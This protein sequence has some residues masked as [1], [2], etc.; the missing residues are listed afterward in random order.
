MSK[1]AP[2]ARLR[3]EITAFLKNTPSVESAGEALTQLVQLAATRVVQEALE[4]EQTDFIGRDRYARAP[5]RGKRNGYVPG[6]LDTAEGRLAVAVP[7]VREAGALYRSV[8]YDFLRGHSDVVQTLAVEMYAR[9]LSTRDIEAAFTDATGTC[10]LSKSA[11]SELTEQLWAE[12]E[13]F[14][15]RDLSEL[16]VLYVFLDGLYEPLRTHGITREAVL[17]AWAITTSGHKVLVH[18][19]L[20]SRESHDDWLGFLRD[21]VRRGLPVPLAITTDG[22]PGL[23]QAVSAVWPKSLRLRCWAHRM[24]N[25]LAKVPEQLHDIVHAEL[26]AIRDAAT[27]AAGQAAA[28]AFLARWGPELPSAATCVSEDLEALLALHRLPWRHRKFVRTTNLIERS[29]VE[30]RRRTKTL[31]RFFTEKSCLKLVYATLIRAAA[32]WQRIVIGQLEHEQLEVLR[33]ELGI[34]ATPTAVKLT[35]AVA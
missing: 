35:T 20:G 27:P 5:G 33:R 7:Q 21:L 8:L 1:L 19:A 31:P 4:Q 16:P 30:E 24:R 3:E 17:C 13:A 22:A 6:H 23:L 15:Q 12:Y 2:S 9:G 18:L 34:A 25:I 28:A 14:S 32:R 10:L 29:F 26:V 11:V